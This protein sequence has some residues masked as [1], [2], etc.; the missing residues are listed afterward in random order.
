MTINIGRK[1]GGPLLHRISTALEEL[2][3]PVSGRS[4]SVHSASK[5]SHDFKRES[6]PHLDRKP[7]E[8]ERNP[9]QQNHKPPSNVIPFLKL[10]PKPQQTGTE[11]SSIQSPASPPLPQGVA[12]TLLELLN[13]FQEQK[14]SLMRWLGS[15]SYSKASQLQ[16]RTSQIRSGS[17]LD[18]KA[19]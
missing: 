2:V 15:R 3:S 6:F 5:A 17:I 19:E 10:E 11:T 4:L 13:M 18:R 14:N 16:K 7:P 8:K 9:E 12:Q 1:S